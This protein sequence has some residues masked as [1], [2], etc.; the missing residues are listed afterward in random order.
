MLRKRMIATVTVK[1]GWVVQ[2]IGYSKYLPIGKVEC[3]LENL[4]RWG[5]DEILVQVIDRSINNLGP[6]LNLLNRIGSLGL[7]TPI[8]YAGG[9]RGKQDAI[10]VIKQGA[11]RIC[12]DSLLHDDIKEIKEISLS[13]GAQAI[14]ACFPLISINSEYNWVDYR[15]GKVKKINEDLSKLLHE[16]K[17]S[18]ILVVD[19]NNEG[20]F[21][22]FDYNLVKYFKDYNVPIIAFGGISEAYQITKLLS[23]LN[24][25]AV[26]IGNFLNYKEHAIQKLKEA[27]YVSSLRNSTYEEEALI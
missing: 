15:S 20:H 25:S 3:V 1:Q 19:K 14:V 4:D 10:D 9:I 17:I 16:D 12:L 11:D 6:D 8:T 21:D 7:S 18:E 5:A 23:N 13:L 24:I 26:S 22:S 27:V 2:S